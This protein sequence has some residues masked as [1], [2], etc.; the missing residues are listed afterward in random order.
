MR[1]RALRAGALVAALFL[2]ALIMS[3]LGEMRGRLAEGLPLMP[4]STV[5]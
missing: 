4:G 2:T 5:R 3:V 1:A